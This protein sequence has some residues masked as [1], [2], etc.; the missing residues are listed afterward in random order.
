M[1][2]VITASTIVEVDE[3]DLRLLQKAKP[4]A[5][6]ASLLAQDEII[7]AVDPGDDA[8]ME[9]WEAPEAAPEESEQELADREA[10]TLQA[11]KDLNDAIA[12][13][14]HEKGMHADGAV[15]GCPV[16]QNES[17]VNEADSV[18]ASEHEAGLHADAAVE[19]CPS[20]QV[21]DESPANG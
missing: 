2:V 20:C 10:T 5:L 14:S 18:R 17:F 15:V 13:A 11:D 8:A 9:V 12:T 16:C 1:K 21:E 6:V 4:R 3:G 7:A 19:D